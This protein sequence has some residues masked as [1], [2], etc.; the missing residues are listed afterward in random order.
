MIPETIALLQTLAKFNHTLR[1]P[2]PL[3]I[4]ELT[5]QSLYIG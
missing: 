1:D 4:Q 3:Q 5:F 2:I